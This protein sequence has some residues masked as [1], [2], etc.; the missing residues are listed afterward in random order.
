LR[1]FALD[2]SLA[3]PLLELRGLGWSEAELAEVRATG[4]P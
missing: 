1:A 3:N 2:P 4:E